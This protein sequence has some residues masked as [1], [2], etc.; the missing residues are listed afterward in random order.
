[1]ALEIAAYARSDEHRLVGVHLQRDLPVIWPQMDP[2]SKR[3][4]Y[5]RQHE[6]VVLLLK[7]AST[8]AC[9]WSPRRSAA[10]YVSRCLP[11]PLREMPYRVESAEAVG[12]EWT[13]A[14]LTYHPDKSDP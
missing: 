1:N 6:R 2:P 5:L 14:V 11:S 4:Q 13:F 8:G 7:A 12:Q 10:T 9:Q 3:K